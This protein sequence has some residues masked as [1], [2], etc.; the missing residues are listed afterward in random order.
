[1]TTLK[2]LSS[3]QNPLVARFRAA[4]DNDDR[5]SVL[6]D[7]AH[8]V[9][10]AI[11][12]GI[13][14][15][16]AIVSS[17]A[18]ARPEVAAL[19]DRLGKLG[20]HVCEAT[21]AVMAAVSPVR[22][23]SAIV[24]LGARPASATLFGG[25]DVL[26]VIACGVQDP[27]NVGAIVR[28]AEAAGA[29][30]FIAAGPTADP[31][32]WKALRGSMGS[33]LRLPID[34]HADVDQAIA[35]ARQRG[36]KIAAALPRGGTPLFEADLAGPLALLVGAEGAGL[37]SAVADS[38]DI[39]LTIPMAGRVESLNTAVSAALMLYEALR[40]RMRVQA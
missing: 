4:I 29:S 38:A 33:A 23:T 25:P 14:I 13:K 22:S 17:G 35:E 5:E 40:Q 9:G 32:G 1:M 6:L 39:R 8:L 3:R 30:G 16:D 24:A 18:T 2:R 34:A 26:V 27:G 28:V 31:F 19:V 12:A 11:A 36:C 7:G 10:E 15:D 21:S 20:A 37:P